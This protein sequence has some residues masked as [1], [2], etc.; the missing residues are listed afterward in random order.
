MMTNENGEQESLVQLAEAYG[1]QASYYDIWGK[2]REIPVSTLRKMLLATGVDPGEPEEALQRLERLGWEQLAPPVLVFTQDRFPSELPFQLPTGAELP[3]NTLTSR[4]RVSLDVTGEDTNSTVFSYSPEQITLREVKQINSDYY[5]RW[6]IPFPDRVNLG[7]HRFDLRVSLA[8]KQHRRSIHVFVC[9]PRCYLPPSLHDNGKRAGIAISLYGL[10]SERN[11]GVGDFGDLK[12]FIHWAMETLHVDVIALN[13]LHAVANR[14]PYNISPYFPSSRFYRNFLYLDIDSMEDYHSCPEAVEFVEMETTQKVLAELRSSE[15]VQYE[16][17]AALKTQV[18]DLVFR[19]FLQQHWHNTEGITERGKEF[20]HYIDREGDILDNFATFCA[21]EAFF[22]E[23]DPEI[24]VWQQWPEPFREVRSE[25]VRTYRRTHWQSILFYKYLQWQVEA[26]L[27]TAQD[28]AHSLGAS[29]GL[30]HDL[31]L[32]ADPSG[33]DLWA[34]RDYFVPS[35]TV[36]AP[37]DDFALEGQQWGFNPPNAEHYHN[38]GYQLFIQEIRNNCRGG[39]ALRIDHIMKF[40]RLFWIPQGSPATDGTYVEYDHQNM[41]PLLALESERNRTLVVGE[42]LGTVPGFVRE[43]LQHFTVLSYRLLYFERESGGFFKDAASYPA[44]SLATIST[45]DLPTLAGFWQSH[46]V[47][48]RRD[49]GLLPSQAEFQASLRQRETDKELIIQRLVA[50]GFLAEDSPSAREV[51]VE[52]TEEVHQAVLG[53]IMSAPAK[54]AVISQEDLFRD[55]RQQNMP[56]TVSEHPNW[57]H[58]MI[59]SL[60]ELWQDVRV[61]HYA[62][63]FRTWV[64]RTGRGVVASN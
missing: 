64:D 53:F 46:D 40:F 38:N 58:K 20:R 12:C 16:R 34:Y 22:H 4:L 30:Y 60:E 56:A 10:K 13:P 39:G 55:L 1:I 23:K 52:L 32:G 37:P 42:D 24:W 14:Q 35:V 28:L 59:Y 45:H 21:L 48:L 5:G 27:Q 41:L 61:Q 44:N 50:S 3:D 36:G 17:V 62:Q 51:P 18:L 6:S 2:L 26:Q 29:V 19:R 9:P 43:V 8:D 33:A 11:W 54:L 7:Q 31:A 63:L 15:L 57:S 49:L 47:F 25:E